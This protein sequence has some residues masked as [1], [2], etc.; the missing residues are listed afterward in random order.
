[1][2]HAHSLTCLQTPESRDPNTPSGCGCLFE[3]N[4]CRE[5]LPS[6]AGEKVVWLEDGDTLTIEGWFTTPDG[7]RAGFGPLSGLV[8][9]VREVV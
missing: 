6:V 2:R 9:P 8:Q 1:M 3:A 5:L 4:A 7:E